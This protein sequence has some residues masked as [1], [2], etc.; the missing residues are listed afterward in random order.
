M[1]LHRQ[2]LPTRR[3][4]IR[5]LR[6]LIPNHFLLQ[7]WASCG[8]HRN[9]DRL[10]YCASGDSEK[11]LDEVRG[12]L[13]SRGRCRMHDDRIAEVR[14]LLLSLGRSARRKF[15]ALE[16]V[17]VESLLQSDR[18]QLHRSR[19]ELRFVMSLTEE[20]RVNEASLEECMDALRLIGGARD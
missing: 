6:K 17:Q 15:H 4:G 7:L 12:K 14:Q 10:A 19:K 16:A 9:R 5:P 18:D 20:R 2:L 8:S 11:I 1:L 3:S 13:G